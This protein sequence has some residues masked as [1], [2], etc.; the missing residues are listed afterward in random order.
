[1]Q[2]RKLGRSKDEISALGFGCMRFP[3][4]EAGKIDRKRTR[5]MLRSA[6]DQGLNYIDTAWPYHGEESEEAVGEILKDGYREKVYLATKMP[7]W[8]IQSQEDMEKYLKLQ[9]ERLQTDHI[10][11]YLVHNLNQTY[12][13]NLKGLD[14]GKFLDEQL[15]K[16]TI[17]YAG[18]SFHDALPLFK[19]IVDAYD[20]TFCQIQYNF[21][22]ETYQAG[23]EGLHYAYQKGLGV[24]VMEPLMGGKLTQKIPQDI[25]AL[26]AQA[27]IQRSPAA[28]GLK[29]LWDQ[30]EVGII[31]S[32]MSDETQVNENIKLAKESVPGHLKDSERALIRQVA[33]KYFEKIQY[34]CTEC[35]YC[36]PCPQNVAIPSMIALY[37]DIFLYEEKNQNRYDTFSN[38][39]KGAKACVACRQCEGK[40]PQ[41]LPI[42]AAL[43]KTV[44]AFEGARA[45]G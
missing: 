38:Q 21:L 26:W 14:V 13:S 3:L 6:I 12:W 40:C 24:I 35:G 5:Q 32:G 39:G 34:G 37:N 18:F 22:N 4:N 9:L 16:G 33:Q 11:Y 45:D 20:W 19:E 25:E 43:K 2:Y 1:M 17:R 42:V 15:K 31:L 44:L 23:R 7:S 30:E 41:H 10:D 29:W 8:L 27:E 36:M 28:W